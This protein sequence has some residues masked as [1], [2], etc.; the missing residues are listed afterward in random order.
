MWPL[1]HNYA[2]ETYELAGSI[3]IG[4]MTGRCTITIDPYAPMVP[5][6]PTYIAPKP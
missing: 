3:C 5:T 4:I 2:N 6:R 1:G